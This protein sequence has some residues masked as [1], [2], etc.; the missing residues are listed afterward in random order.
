M[1]SHIRA[2]L[3]LFGLS[4]LLGCVIYP[5]LLLAIGQTIFH[6]KAQGSLLTD[7]KGNLVGSRLIAQPFSADE[8]F[9]PRPSAA[10]YNGGASGASNWGANSPKLRDRVAQAIGPV[11]K[12]AGGPKDGQLVG[13]DVEAWF[14]KDQF[15]GKP[16]IVAQ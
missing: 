15:G 10:S 8:Y 4:L 16:G 12:Y 6:D 11:A 1:N 13:P 9:Q 14:Q 5:L 2:N 7:A 3:W